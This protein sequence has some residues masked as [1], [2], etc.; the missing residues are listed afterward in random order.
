[1]KTK[2]VLALVILALL[3]ILL[4]QN[5]QIVTYRL[6]F[7]SVSLSQIILLP[8]AVLAGFLIG[9]LTAKMSGRGKK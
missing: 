5:T 6:Y 9:F 2:L 7:W 3:V 1:V 4:I 8:L